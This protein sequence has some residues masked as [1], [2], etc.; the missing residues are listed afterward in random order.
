MR[1][2]DG[3]FTVTGKAVTLKLKSSARKSGW[4]KFAAANHPDEVCSSDSNDE[5]SCDAWDAGMSDSY[6]SF[7]DIIADLSMAQPDSLVLGESHYRLKKGSTGRDFSWTGPGVVT[8][9]AEAMFTIK[10]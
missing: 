7:D 6:T 3:S 8:D 10:A 1:A 5:T 4:F 2:E 9:S